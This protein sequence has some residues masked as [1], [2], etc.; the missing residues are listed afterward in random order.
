L[1]WCKRFKERGRN[2]EREGEGEMEREMERERESEIGE[3][4]DFVR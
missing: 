4:T 1:R 3:S 2:F